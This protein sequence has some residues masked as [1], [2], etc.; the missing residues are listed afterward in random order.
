VKYEAPGD[1]SSKRCGDPLALMNYHIR[2][3][4]SD[5]KQDLVVIHRQDAQE[6]ILWFSR[7][8]IFT[9]KARRN[10]RRG[11]VGPLRFLH[12]KRAAD[13]CGGNAHACGRT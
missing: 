11:P 13:Y 10:K 9:W 3:T 2:G 7:H 5:D 6:T 8:A 12:G 4:F 1:P